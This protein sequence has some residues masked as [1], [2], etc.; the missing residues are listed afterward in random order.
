MAAEV[1]AEI[2]GLVGP[3]AAEGLD[4][5]A[6]E[7][8]AR[9]RVLSVA[10]R[11][12][13]R[14][15]N[16]DHSD[17]H[18]PTFPCPCGKAARYAGRRSKALQ[19]VLGE[20]RLERAYYHCDSCQAGFC[21]RDRAL[22][23]EGTSLSPAVTRMIAAVGASASFQES[24]TLL[25][26]L[27]GLRLDAKQVERTAEAVGAE[28]AEDERTIV[29]SVADPAPAPTL[30]L[31]LD[32][33]GI[34]MRPEELAGRAG[35]Q[36]DGSAKTREV[37]ICALWSA[38]GRD[39]EGLPVRDTGS[40]TYSA[41][42]ESAALSDTEATYPAFALRV[43][44][45]TTRRGFDRARRQG[46][47]GDGAPW[48]WKLADEHFPDAIQ[49]LDRYHAKEYLTRAAQ[50]IWG[51]DSEIGR[52]WAQERHAELDAGDLDALVRAYSVHA[53]TNE[54]ARNCVDYL[55]AN[56][57]RM[58]YPAFHAAGL[59]T[60]TG[61]LEA[62]CRVVVAQRLKRS[63][64]HWTSRGANRILALRAARLSHRFEDFWQRR[65]QPA[66]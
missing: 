21:P 38:E 2:E 36:P 56:R 7:M 58:R 52:Q 62:G 10:A 55:R 34:P 24:S 29:E 28:I 17:H 51:A 20:M 23:F 3:G 8:A 65:R 18:G 47:L 31:G 6:I 30:Y 33:T 13:A 39:A 15:L 1:I 35:K 61:V 57:H 48:I 64:M 26:E 42:I 44:R 41:A 66:A 46:I 40:V 49:I 16:A 43:L 11:A 50:A 19:T 25:A 45:E 60:S 5:E 54:E 27:A 22:G 9:R 59:C 14:R 4:F 12:V 53:S 32:G 37:K 63:G